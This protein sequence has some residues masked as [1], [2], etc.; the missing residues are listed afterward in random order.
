M[1]KKDLKKD[2]AS[3]KPAT[4]GP[5]GKPLSKYALWKLAHPDAAKGKS[6]K[7]EQK[8]GGVVNTVD[9]GNGAGNEAQVVSADKIPEPIE[10][11]ESAI[12]SKPIEVKSAEKKPKKA[13][14]EVASDADVDSAKLSL[15]QMFDDIKKQ[16]GDESVFVPALMDVGDYPR[17]HRIPVSSP[18]IMDLLGGGLPESRSIEIFSQ[19]ES[20]GKTS[21]ACYFA[22]EVQ[23]Q[24]SIVAYIDAE[25][26]LDLEY[27]KTF[28]LD[29]DHMMFSQPSS[30]EAALNMVLAYV[31]KKIGLVIVDSVSMLTPQAEIDGE[32][33][34][35]HMALQARMMSQALRA[36]TAAQSKSPTIIIWI[37]Q[38]R[39]AI[40]KWAPHG[41]V[42]MDTSGGKALKFAASIRI[43]V[44]KR[45][46]EMNPEGEAV[47]QLIRLKTV[48]N[49]VAPPFR[50]REIRIRFGKGI[51][52]DRDWFD[53][54]IIFNIIVRRGGGHL[55]PDGHKE[56]S[57][58][59]AWAY[60]ISLD[61][62]QKDNI[63]I[64][65]KKAMADAKEVPNVITAET[66]ESGVQKTTRV[67]DTEESE[68]G[69]EA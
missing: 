69:D 30:G 43:E 34:D 6:T 66:I 53:Y 42:P 22:G 44:K 62:L 59:K 7:K 8:F 33:G 35:A 54:A 48:K 36:I 4:V 56:P 17:V 24:G 39:V 52:M 28:G 19:E 21:L 9:E 32:I 1:A 11:S 49:K 47:S 61:R 50:I 14:R 51:E 63:I 27:A 25:Q 37:N 23:K 38:S 5:D 18:K 26:A 60:F 68:D 13:K 64:A 65:T 58:E 3:A 57:G 29:V 20:A 45:E 12:S 16:F 40:G 2:A 55:F 10:K 31:Q 15:N 46:L 67:E 41:Q